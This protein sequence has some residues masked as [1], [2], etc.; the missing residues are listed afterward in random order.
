MATIFLN[1]EK[2]KRKNEKFLIYYKGCTRKAK[3]DVRRM[4]DRVC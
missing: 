4:S 1:F 2:Q 3:P